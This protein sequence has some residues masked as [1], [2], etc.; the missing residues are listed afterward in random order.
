MRRYGMPS[1]AVLS[2]YSKD[3]KQ[4]RTITLLRKIYELIPTYT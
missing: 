2:R 4:Y 3:Q 1:N